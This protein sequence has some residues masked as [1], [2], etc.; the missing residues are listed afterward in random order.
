MTRLGKPFLAIVAAASALLVNGTSAADTG[1]VAWVPPT[2]AH[3][4]HLT[5]TLGAKFALNLIA[6]AA[7]VDAIVLVE[8]TSGLPKG[9]TIENDP[10]AGT[11]FATFRWTPAQVGE[12][13]LGFRAAGGAGAVSS[14]LT[15]VI[16]VRAKVAY[17]RT[18]DLSD[19]RT[20]HWS[21]VARRVSAH[22]RPNASSPVV[23]TL[24]QTTPDR[25]QNL[26]LVL[27]GI[28]RSPSETWFRVRLPILPNN[29]TGWVPGSALGKLRTVYT[30]L[31][32]DL[33]KL[34]ATLDVNGR[35]VFRT[36]V[37]VGRKSWP[38]PRGEFYIRSRL[39]NFDDPFYGPV[40]FAT[41]ARSARLTD[42]PGGAFV[43]VHGTDQPELLPGRVSHGCIRM[44]NTSIVA[45]AKLMPV[46]TPLTIR[47]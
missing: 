11:A 24:A 42:W 16:E 17:P 19:H 14:T 38:T 47:P 32:V 37:G 1:G 7:D 2:P 20:A 30:H 4:A 8:P 5:A 18:Y 21:M 46:G 45:L 33:T 25:T 27:E 40:A 39:T 41:S 43:G 6:S 26:V 10:R 22:V 35:P 23:T 34:T 3:N 44:P 29:T 36:R 28:D 13:V 12:Y 9:A 31:Y 15:Y